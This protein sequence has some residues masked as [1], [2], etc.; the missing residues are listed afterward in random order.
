MFGEPPPSQSQAVTSAR[1]D[2]SSDMV[3]EL[4]SSERFDPSMLHVNEEVAPTPTLI[5]PVAIS[6]GLWGTSDAVLIVESLSQKPKA[7]D[8]A[9][10]GAIRDVVPA[11]VTVSSSS[12]KI[13]KLVGFSM[14]C[15]K[16]IL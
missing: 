7:S 2:I 5:A 4:T 11:G 6:K 3:D 8:L 15:I 1:E 16:S 14:G 10:E 13:W 12:S 9:T